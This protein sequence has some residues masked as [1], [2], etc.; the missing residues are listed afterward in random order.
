[1]KRI[2]NPYNWEENENIREMFTTKTKNKLWSEADDNDANFSEEYVFWLEERLLES[3]FGEESTLI[4]IL[5][6]SDRY[7]RATSLKSFLIADLEIINRKVK[8]L[9]K[10]K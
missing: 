2:K 8:E 5:N 9:L 1:M 10:W 6:Q 4:D 7:L 3:S